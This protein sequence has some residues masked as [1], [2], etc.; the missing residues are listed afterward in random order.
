MCVCVLCVC[1]SVSPLLSLSLLSLPKLAVE[2]S[3][4]LLLIEPNL[5]YSRW[6]RFRDLEIKKY[7]RQGSGGAFSEGKR[8]YVLGLPNFM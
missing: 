4:S 6:R 8:L 1:V 5:R 2:V 3:P 7:G